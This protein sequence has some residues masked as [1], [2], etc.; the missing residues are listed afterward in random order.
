MKCLVTGGCGFIGSALVRKLVREGHEVLN[1][2]CLT[3]AGSPLNVSDVSGKELY[4]FAE[5]DVCDTDTLRALAFDFRPDLIF[6]L[7]AESHV[8]R[9]IDQPDAFLKSNVFGTY[10]M[11]EVFRE[12]ASNH[13]S[14]LIHVST[15][16][17]FG[18]LGPSGKFTEDSPYKPNSPYS[19]SKAASDHLVRAWG[20]TYSLPVLLT[21]CSNNYGPYQLPE[22][23][24]PVVIYSVLAAA[25]VPIYGNGMQVRD[26][27]HVDD[28]VDGLIAVALKGS[29]GESYNIGGGNERTN[30]DLIREILL[31]LSELKSVPL[32]QYAALLS[33]VTDRPGHDIRYA[34]DASKIER[35]LG[36]RSSTALSAGLRNT[37]E[38]YL[39]NE[40]WVRSVAPPDVGRRLGLG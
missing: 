36:W 9:S 2:D 22:K 12:L 8:D 24:I 14:R 20:E 26:W 10:S 32:Q 19:A 37:V 7:A 39:A 21:N 38:W 31:V 18:S 25:D 29:E 4:H 1:V 28:H 11:L 5:L 40:T 33:F 30:I 23:L 27:L 6:H 16:E 3:Y 13:E 15:D 17:V 34:I 35:E